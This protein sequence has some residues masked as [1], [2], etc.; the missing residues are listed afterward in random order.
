LGWGRRKEHVLLLLVVGISAGPKMA[1]RSMGPAREEASQPA[2][3]ISV[4]MPDDAGFLHADRLGAAIPA[5]KASSEWVASSCTF[6]S[7][8]PIYIDDNGREAAP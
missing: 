2:R 5:R 6:T 8:A 1:A 3:R 7:F 4:G